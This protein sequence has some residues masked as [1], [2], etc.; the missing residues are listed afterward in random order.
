MVR[1]GRPPTQ[2]GA[3]ATRPHDFRVVGPFFVV[4]HSA[5]KEDEDGRDR[6]GA[7][8]LPRGRRRAARGARVV[9]RD[10]CRDGRPEVLRPARHVAARDAADRLV[11]RVRVRRGPRLRRLLDPRLAGHRGER[12]AA[13][14]RRVDGDPRPVHRGADALAPLRDRR[15]RHARA[16][17]EGSAPRREARTRST[18]ARPASPTRATS[19]PSASSSSSTRCRTRAAPNEARYK[20]DSR[21]ATGTP[22]IPASA[23]RSARSRATSRPRRTTR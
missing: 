7:A 21:R 9:A 14:A 2:A 10:E 18:C 6:E 4:Q 1:T 13:D 17:R 20:V 23:T 15:A 12:H 5:Q 3:E 19:A 8:A 16:V 11:R 22:A